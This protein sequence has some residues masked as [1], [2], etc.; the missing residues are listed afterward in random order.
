[1][2]S[3]FIANQFESLLEKYKIKYKVV[4]P[5][6]PLTSGQFKVSNREI[7][8]GNDNLLLYERLSNKT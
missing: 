6:H 2:G 4:T 1:M 3:H 7:Y 8:H 5:Y